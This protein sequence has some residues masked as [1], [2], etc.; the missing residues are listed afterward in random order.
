MMINDCTINNIP[1]VGGNVSLYNET[2]GE[3]IPPTPQIGAVGIIKDV[4]KYV[5]NFPS[6]PNDQNIILIGD[7]K[8]HLSCSIYAQKIENINKGTPPPIDLKKELKYGVFIQEL[9]SKELITSCRDLSDG[10][11]GIALTELC[12]MSKIGCKI[13][14]QSPDIIAWLFGEDQSR[15]IITCTDISL[16]NITENARNRNISAEVIGRLVGKNFEVTEQSKKTDKISIDKLEN[17][18]NCG[19][20]FAFDFKEKSQRDIFV[21]ELIDNK[22]LCNPTR[23]K[24]IRLR[25]NLCVTAD[26]VDHA[27]SIIQMAA[28]KI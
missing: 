1:I 14:S 26:E 23:D 18:R 6:E 9:C 21:K 17:I 19:L 24:T 2:E 16:E 3:S 8:G 15:Y 4:K 20:L 11:L 13:E 22:M 25:P 27:L 28:A 5:S 7:T 12:L 10:G